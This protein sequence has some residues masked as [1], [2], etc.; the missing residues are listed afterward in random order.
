MCDALHFPAEASRSADSETRGEDDFIYVD[1]PIENIEK[2]SSNFTY[3]A[4]EYTHAKG[5]YIFLHLL[6]VVTG[7]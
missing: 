1:P 4:Q 7:R 6:L 2:Y 3:V 5:I